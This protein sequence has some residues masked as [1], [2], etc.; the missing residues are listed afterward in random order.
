MSI[1]TLFL[2]F[3]AVF[4][5]VKIITISKTTK[6]MTDKIKKDAEKAKQNQENE[7]A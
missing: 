2:I 3:L 1:E 4:S 6:L 7:Q 5:I